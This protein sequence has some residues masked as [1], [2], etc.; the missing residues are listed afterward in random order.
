MRACVCAKASCAGSAQF[1]SRSIDDFFLERILPREPG[2]RRH[3]PRLFFLII[4]R[5]E[6]TP[7]CQVDGVTP[8]F[9]W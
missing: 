7:G 2:T 4:E 8:G 6:M 3:P 5:D 9:F 1:S